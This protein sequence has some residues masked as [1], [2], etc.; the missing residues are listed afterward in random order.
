MWWMKK[1]SPVNGNSVVLPRDPSGEKPG[2]FM[3]GADY[4]VPDHVVSSAEIE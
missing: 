4:Y 1:K 3:I 2:C